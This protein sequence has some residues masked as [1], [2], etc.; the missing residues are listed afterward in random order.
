MADPQERSFRIPRLSLPIP[1]PLRCRYRRFRRDLATVAAGMRGWLP[2]LLGSTV[3][4]GVVLAWQ[5]VDDERHR[6]DLIRRTALQQ[7]DFLAENLAIETRDWAHWDPTRQHALGVLADYYGNGNFNRDTFQ[8]TPYVMVLNRRGSV[9]ST[10][11]WHTGRGRA[12]PLPLNDQQEILGALPL[13]RQLEPRTFLAMLR[14]RPCLISAQPIEG[15]TGALPPVGRLLFARPLGP[16]DGD[17][18]RH[19]LALQH[20]RI[21]PVRRLTSPPL[22]PLALALRA[23]RWDGVQPLQISVRRPA[24]ERRHALGAFAALLLVNGLL[25]GAVAG[26]AVCQHRLVRHQ[27][28]R[29]QR[30]ERRLRRALHRR[31]NLDGLTGLHNRNGLLA[32]LEQQRGENPQ[33]AQALLQIDIRRFA[34]INTSAGRPF[35]DRVLVALTQWLERRL[36]PPAILART[37]GDEFTCALMGPSSQVL[38]AAITELS[39]ELQ[40]LDLLVDG[41]ILHLSVSA[42]ARLLAELSPMAALQEAGVA[43]DLARRSGRHPCRF[44]GD[45]PTAMRSTVEIQELNQELITALREERIA[46]FAQA[47]WRIQDSRLPAVYLELLARLRDPLS[48]DHHWSEQLVAAATHCG[49][50]PLLDAHVFDLGCRSLAQLLEQHSGDSPVA[51]LVYAFNV[52]PDTLLEDGFVASVERRLDQVGLEASRLCFEI[53]EQAAARDPDGVCRVMRQLRRL[54]IRFSLD[55]FGAGMTSLSHLRDL[56]LDYVKIDKSFVAGLKDNPLSRLTVEFVVRMGREQGFQTIAEG[57][58]DLAVLYL[59]RDLG[60]DIAQGYAT[61]R[62]SLF[63]PLADDSFARCG[64]ERLGTGPGSWPPA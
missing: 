12:E 16:R 35:G 25:V 6:N 43:L 56:P 9:V 4:S 51:D 34:L 54:G 63:D 1:L 14:G 58:E 10:A 39:Q 11:H 32:A 28:G 62:P 31:E 45:E 61:A 15:P 64:G 41:Q 53:T 60:V 13:R 48:E 24:S 5:A 18:A 17:F 42:G 47:A 57:V 38:R 7:L 2:L 23:P 36:P 52:T 59:L 8:R 44:Y 22:G 26:R 27:M 3:V 29:Q 40:Q 30:E 21:E 33:L 37:G 49:S 46:L 55:D 50:M 20:Y 19:A